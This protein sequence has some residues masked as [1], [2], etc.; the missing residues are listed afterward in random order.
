[1]DLNEYTAEWLVRERLAEARAYA[2]RQSLI[3]SVRPPRRPARVALGNALIRAGHWM[4][5]QVPAC[6]G[7]SDRAR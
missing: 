7:A 6:V 2:R 3:E 1:M 5:G 4:L